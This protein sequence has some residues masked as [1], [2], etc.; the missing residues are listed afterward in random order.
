MRE[1]KD[2][3]VEWIGEIPKDYNLVKLKKVV[4]HVNEKE[5]YNG[6]IY[7][8]L[9]NIES[10]NG[11]FIETENKKTEGLSSIFSENDILFCKLRPYLAKCFHSNLSGLCSSE[12][13]VL[14]N[15]KGSQRFLFWTLLSD[16][17]IKVVD[18]STY[19]AKMP[20]A[21]WDFI[22][23]L[24]ICV[25][26]EAEQQRIATY[27]DQKCEK[28]DA[29]LNQQK[30]VIEKLKEYKQS[31]ITETVTKGLNLN[32]AMKDS[33]VE[34]IGDIPEG[35]GVSKIKHFTS[36]I[37]SG[38]TPFG[39]AT[40]YLDTGIIFL[41]SQNIHNTG[42]SIQDIVCISEEIDEE[43]KTTRVYSGDVLLNI[44]GASIGRA[45]IYDLQ[46]HANV[47]QHVC[48]IRIK[49][50]LLL[51]RL[52][53]YILIS[54]IGFHSINIYQSGANREGLNFDQIGNMNIPFTDVVEQKQIADYLD[55]KCEL[56]DQAIEQKQGIIEKLMEYKKSLIYE[57]VTGKVEV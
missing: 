9:E 32:V 45:S 46:E 52:L 26:E 1:L 39:G 16:W 57:C 4:D 5:P 25:P 42:L 51:N 10:Q 43:M 55:K 24:L 48:I 21:S 13:L 38:K 12:L 41:R 47:N 7:I 17:V 30:L 8:G 33:G 22:G 3:G 15:F 34:W 18:S 53:H 20:R 49:G 19:G 56:V 11:K 31:L 36:K 2:S 27:L 23:D 44:T 54:D 37:G 29:T 6:Q 50:T 28:I 40:V 35:W 14:R